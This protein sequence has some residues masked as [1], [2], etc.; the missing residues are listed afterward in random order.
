M[1]HYYDIDEIIVE[2]EVSTFIFSYQMV[3]LGK[4]LSLILIFY[5]VLH[6]MTARLYCVPKSGKW[7]WNP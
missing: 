3:L 5:L 1:A 6:F 7:S 4:N 2:E